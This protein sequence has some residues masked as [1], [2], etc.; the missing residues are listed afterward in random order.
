MMVNSRL[1][2]ILE[3]RKSGICLKAQV[4]ATLVA[5]DGR[6]FVGTNGVRV[7][8]EVCPR[9]GSPHFTGY[10][11]CKDICRQESHAEVSAINLAGE[12]ARGATIYLEGHFAPCPDCQAAADAA[13]IAQIIIGAPPVQQ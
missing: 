8:Q 5:L 12:A 11:A 7:P 10:E 13:G 3:P 9:A 1:H 4:R 2:I 6:W